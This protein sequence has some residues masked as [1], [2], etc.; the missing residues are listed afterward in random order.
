LFPNQFVNAR[1]RVRTLTHATLVPTEAV[2]HNGTAAFVYLVNPQNTVS[3]QPITAITSN[4]NVTAVTGVNAGVTLATSGFDRLENGAPVQI[5]QGAK[6]ASGR[7]GMGPTS[8]GSK[9]P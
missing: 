2:Q 7:R 8:G 5:H 6:A 4:D 9:T 1:L 3:V